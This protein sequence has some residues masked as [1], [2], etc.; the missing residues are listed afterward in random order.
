M[1]DVAKIWWTHDL[2]YELCATSTAWVGGDLGWTCV[3]LAATSHEAVSQL[4]M[5]LCPKNSR[6]LALTHGC[7]SVCAPIYLHTHQ[8]AHPI[9]TV[10]TTLVDCHRLD[11]VM[12]QKTMQ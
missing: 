7:T 4:A 8:Y 2:H 6:A 9:D 3:Q 11:R 1:A 5:K 12:A 10:A